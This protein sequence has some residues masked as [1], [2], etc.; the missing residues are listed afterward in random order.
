MSI[1]DNNNKQSQKD[2]R[3][4]LFDKVICVIGVHICIEQ[5]FMDCKDE[6]R[7]AIC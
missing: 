4:L 7:D 2:R 6:T 3:S 1:E 5:C